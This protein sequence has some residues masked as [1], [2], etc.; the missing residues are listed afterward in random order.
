MIKTFLNPEGHQNRI[1]GSK[2]TAILL[3]RWI[4]P[5]GGGSSGEGLRLQ[6]AQQACFN[7]RNP[8]FQDLFPLYGIEQVNKGR[9]ISGAGFNMGL[10]YAIYLMLMMVAMMIMMMMM[11]NTIISWQ[12]R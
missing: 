2:V 5:I 3:K 6:P 9:N 12:W 11:M 10:N 1:S 4:L 7:N 8:I